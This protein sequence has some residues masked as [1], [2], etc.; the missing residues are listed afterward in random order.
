MTNNQ[1]RLESMFNLHQKMPIL[2]TRMARKGENHYVCAA[3][4]REI[5]CAEHL[6]EIS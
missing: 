4:G 5:A 2:G 6:K 1:T 3:L